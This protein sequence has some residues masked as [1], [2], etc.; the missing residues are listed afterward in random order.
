MG[1]SGRGLSLVTGERGSHS[2]SGPG[3]LILCHTRSFSLLQVGGGALTF[4]YPDPLS[5]LAY[6]VGGQYRI[7]RTTH[8]LHFWIKVEITWCGEFCGVFFSC[9]HYREV[10]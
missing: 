5:P 1:W 4:F 10:V 3:V 8:F 9:K 2:P 7:L 6:E